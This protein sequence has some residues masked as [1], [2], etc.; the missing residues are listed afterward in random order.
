MPGSPPGWR[1]DRP[2]RRLWTGPGPDPL[3]S[4][5]SV[6]L[7]QRRREKC[8]ETMVF[9]RKRMVHKGGV[10]A[11]IDSLGLY[12][13]FQVKESFDVRPIR[14]ALLVAVACGGAACK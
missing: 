14:R 11:C 10:T 12:C 7:R 1:V 4:P 13:V 8:F 9:S 5:K 6:L 2:A 3:W